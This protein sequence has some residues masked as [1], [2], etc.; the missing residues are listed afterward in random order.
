M[1]TKSYDAVVIGGGMG[2]YVC[3]I[4][5]T[6][7]G[8]KVALVEKESLGGVCLNWGCIPSKA[9]IA[10]ANLVEDARGAAARGITAEPKVDLVRLRAFKDEVVKKLVGGVGLLTKGNGVE[11]LK[12]TAAFVAPGA[13]EVRGKEGTDRVEAQAFVVATGARPIEIPGFPFG[14][15]VWSAKE[16]VELAEVPP[17]LAVIGGGVIGLELGTVY[18]KL[19]S[20]VT[21][22]EALPQ[23]LTGID[24][25]A[26]RLVAKGLRQRA[27]RVLTGA[28][29][30]G[31]GRK[32]GSLVLL[33]EVEGKEEPIECDR[34]L[35][36]VGFRPWTEGL[37]LEKA[38]VKLGPKGFVEVNDRYQT[39]VPTI[40]A[41]GDLTGPPFLAHK[42]AKEGEIAAEV[43]SGRKSARDW[44]AMPGAIFTDPEIGVAGMSEEEARAA[45][46]DPITGKFSF[47]ALGRAI[48][49]DHTEGFVKVI[50][51]RASKRLLGAVFAGPEASNLVAEATLALEMGATLEDV[52]LTVHAHPTLP[53]A[54]QEACLAAMGEAIHALN[55]PERSKKAP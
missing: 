33:A 54:F 14:G 3:A 10:A 22:V 53:E 19:G 38:G 47:G 6:Q 45:G 52:A 23:I 17:R 21:V 20:K 18:A 31:L 48:A 46:H 5:M 29:A 7:L 11:V 26:V 25:E 49:I 16:A 34:V 39:S 2:G 1:A 8:K 51:D 43:I 36:A 13:V 27:V 35:V 41:V 44:V 12:G 15:D 28:K 37:G 40:F 24:G 32:S 50:A 55:R 4:R 30:K 42:A 9:L